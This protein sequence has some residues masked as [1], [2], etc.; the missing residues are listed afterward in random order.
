[1]SGKRTALLGT[2]L[3]RAD[4]TD[5]AL[6][7]HLRELIGRPLDDAELASARGILVDVGAVAEIETAI[8]DLLGNALAALDSADIGDEIRA[9]LTAV[10]HRT[11]H[12]E[13]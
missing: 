9:E 3:R 5:P 10:A 4:D 12:R 8:D 1:M 13:A 7:Q 11:A 2:A 6:G